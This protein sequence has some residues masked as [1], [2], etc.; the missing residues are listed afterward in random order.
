VQ[1]NLVLTL[2][3]ARTAQ[4][5]P[6]R[7]AWVRDHDEVVGVIIQSPLP[8]YAAVTEIPLAAIDALVDRLAGTWPDI[9]G[10]FGP[11]GTVAQLAGS[12]AETLAVAATPVEGQ[13][14]YV[15]GSLIPP[16][17]VPGR[18]R[19]ATDAD[20]DL[21]LAWAR[22][23]VHDTGAPAASADT[24]RCRLRGGLVR[25]WEHRSPVSMASYTPAVAGVSRVGGV[26]TPAANRGH[27]YA[28]AC[29]A[30]TTCAALQAGAQH[31]VL[32]TQLANP[33][34]NAIYR[35]LGY[36]SVSEH[37]RYQFTRRTAS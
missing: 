33:Q 29:T 25:I 2:L 13:R 12:W 16:T 37:L 30:A 11:A 3:Q 6:G 32:Y 18:L 24:L 34:S 4:P 26:Y 5:E 9:P 8:L 27:G 28:T 1:H 22:E 23:F 17:G 31:C 20:A 35:H 10:V 36:Q 21:V 7:Y 14:L 19:T 15:L